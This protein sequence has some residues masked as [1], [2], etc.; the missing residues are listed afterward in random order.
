MRHDAHPYRA[1]FRPLAAAVGFALATAVCAPLHGAD[2]TPTDRVPYTILLRG[3][4]VA[5]YHG[6]TPGF[7]APPH[8]ALGRKAGRPDL[9]SPA[10]LAY[11]DYLQQ[12]QG[13]FVADLERTLG[14]SLDVVAK[15]QHALNGIIVDL[16]D[17]EAARIAQRADVELVERE[18]VLELDTDRGP[19]FIGAPSI[20]DGTASGGV[21]TKG[22]GIVVADLDTGI[23]WQSPAFAATGPTDG[24]A[25][26]NPNGAG[27]YLGLCG[28]TPPNADAGRC[29]DKLIGMYNFTTTSATRSGEDL[30]G[31]GSHTAS[32]IVGNHWQAPFGGG[33]FLVSGV[34]PHANVIAYKVCT[35]GCSSSASSQATNQ[36][37]ADGADV[38]NFSISGGVSPWADSVSIAFRNAVGAGVFVAA[39]AGN[40]GPVAGS[41]NHVEPWVETVAASTKDNVVAFR[42]DLV[43]PGTP[44]PGTQGLPLRPAAP[45][46]PT[47]DIV[48]A[49]IVRS[50]T[51]ADGSN[52]GCSAFAADTF[53]VE[54]PADPDLVFA[55]GLDGPIAPARLGAIAVLALDQNASNCGSVARRTNALAA[56][57]IGVIFVDRDFINLGASATSWSMLRADWDAA[58]TQIQT[59]PAQATASLLLPASSFPQRGD[60]VADF[61]SRGPLA[62]NGQYLVKPNITA[63]GVDILASYAAAAGGANSTALENGTSMSSPHTTGSAALLRAVHPDWTPTEVRSALNMTAKLDGLIRADGSGVN[64]WDLGSGR[65]DLTHA[66]LAGLVLDE[67]AANFLAAN[68]GSGGTLA[69]L[70]LAEFTSANCATTCTF[71]RSVRSPVVTAQ[72]YTITFSG[73]PAGTVTT[74]TPSLPIAA[75]ATASFGIQVDGSMLPAGWSYGD[76]TLTP[77]NA[78]QPVLHMPIAIHR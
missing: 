68:P 3:E 31:H 19:A 54:A 29:N 73:L 64:V 22:E 1:R 55:D 53:T 7:A 28:P 58:W 69:T 70:N 33:T 41:V 72:T 11:V 25:H 30:D 74:A 49:P 38:L 66:A 56:G 15:M 16:D 57:A 50:P 43:G 39:S 18:R 23:N 17:A 20:W 65:V 27:N 48:A 52:D 37:V 63:P 36:A 67:S 59:D 26:V 8:V 13:T 32:T 2:G 21:A 62:N 76:V 40:D 24:Y 45:P 5:T 42:F 47:E 60:V 14:R 71:T 75:G 77:D 6:G 51:F 34:A 61:S 9:R 35:T 4:P 12:R 46:L 44:P 10:A 78:V